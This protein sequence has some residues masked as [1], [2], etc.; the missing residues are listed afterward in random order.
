VTLGF[1]SVP[2][3]IPYARQ[4]KTLPVVVGAEEVV[5]FLEAMP[6]QKFRIAL[7][8]VRIADFGSDRVVIRVRHGRDDKERYVMLSEQLL[9]ILRDYWRVTGPTYW[10][11][12]GSNES[13]P[14]HPTV[15]H[16]A[17]PSARKA[18]GL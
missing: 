11:F 5:R 16:A 1:E 13:K 8:A 6:S 2:E 17:Y 4:P 10:L 7:T 14:L 18:A 12:P 15:I 3:C 9:A